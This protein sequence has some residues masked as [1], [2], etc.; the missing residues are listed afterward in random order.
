M[1]RRGDKVNAFDALRGLGEISDLTPADVDTSKGGGVTS[2][3]IDS[4]LP[5]PIQA[6]RVL[7]TQLR[8]RFF[9]GELD[10]VETLEAW[11]RLAADDELEAAVLDTQVVRLAKSLQAQEQINPITISQA[12]TEETERYLIETGERRWWAHWWLVG[13]E[14]DTRFEM[15]QAVVVKQ[16]SPWRQAAENLQGEPLSA[17]QEACQVAR[18]LL[19][20]AGIEPT[21][22]IEWVGP[23]VSVELEDTG[24]GFYRQALE[25]RAPR[26]AWAEIEQAT[27]KGTRYCQYLLGLLRLDDAVLELADRAGLNEGQLR[28]LAASG[29]DAERQERLIGLVVEYELSRDAVATL[30]RKPDLDEAERKLAERHAQTRKTP[31]LRPPE[32]I[33]LARLFSITRLLDRAS[34]SEP[35]VLQVIAREISQ[36]E[37]ADEQRVELGNLHAF[38]GDLLSLLEPGVDQ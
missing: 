15:V 20:K 21:Y 11:Q 33:V 10:P 35:A 17:V 16:A 29:A 37:T 2:I 6:R 9:A 26:G 12:G 8:K 24:Y 5:D 28:P 4:I 22:S 14:G 13:M 38:L 25:H 30:V 23:S 18:L 3:S 34:R 32:K 27:G 1:S 31:V 19:L 7:P 36:M